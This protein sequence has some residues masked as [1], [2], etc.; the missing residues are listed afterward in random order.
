MSTDTEKAFTT[1]IISSK[2]EIECG[3]DKLLDRD[4]KSEGMT[5]GGFIRIKTGAVRG[6]GI[7]SQRRI[8][9]TKFGIDDK[10]SESVV[11]KSL[12]LSYVY[13]PNVA[14]DLEDLDCVWY[15]G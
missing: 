8:S 12:R 7:N 9:H 14:N 3:R 11:I 5:L 13:H 6:V 1:I 4:G 15:G 2:E 10:R